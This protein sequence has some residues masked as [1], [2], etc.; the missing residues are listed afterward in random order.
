[1]HDL[2]N[3]RFL[4]YPNFIPGMLSTLAT[5]ESS[6]VNCHMRRQPTKNFEIVLHDSENSQTDER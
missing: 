1:M 5:R 4:N 3:Y 6:I 2:N